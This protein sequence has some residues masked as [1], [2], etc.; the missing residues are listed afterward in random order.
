LP[1]R[2]HHVAIGYGDV[3]GAGVDEEEAKKQNIKIKKGGKER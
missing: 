2:R 1:V 3:S